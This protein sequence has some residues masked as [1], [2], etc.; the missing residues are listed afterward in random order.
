MRILIT[1]ANGF[2]GQNVLASLSKEKDAEFVALQRTASNKSLPEIEYW[3]YPEINSETISS[4]DLSSI[5][6]VLHALATIDISN[7]NADEIKAEYQ[8]VN[9]ELTQVL[10]NHA[11]NAGVKQFIFISSIKV[12]GE[13]TKK[14]ESPFSEADIPSPKDEYALSKLA[15]ENHLKTICHESNMT[16]TIIRP[17]LV[18]GPGVKGN[19]EKLIKLVKKGYPLPFAKMKNWRSVLAVNNLSDF[20]WTCIQHPKAKNETFLIADREDVST[21]DLV[22]AISEAYEK[23]LRLF[24]IPKMPL[25]WLLTCLG[26][27]GIYRKLYSCLILR[28][29]KA[30]LLL[31]WEPVTDLAG[32]LRKIVEREK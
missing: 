14:T 12:N 27:E 31:G 32:Q 16:Y 6:V 9:V 15:A 5:D 10:A 17:P 24:Y 4:L 11:A 26:K 23:S 28:K 19:F 3:L 7:K 30:R 2:V 29:D 20:I 13:E 1:G 25:R 22:I 8:K 18:Y 21:T